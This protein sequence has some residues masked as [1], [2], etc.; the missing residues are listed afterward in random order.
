MKFWVVGITLFCWGNLAFG[1]CEPED[2][3]PDHYVIRFS[4][5]V[6]SSAFQNL[7][8][9]TRFFR[10]LDLAKTRSS[11][12]KIPETVVAKIN[13]SE[14]SRFISDYGSSVKSIEPVCRY[15]LFGTINPID[16]DFSKQWNL[17][18]IKAPTAWARTTGLN[19]IV[20]AISDSGVDWKHHEFDGRIW[21]N[22]KEVPGNGIDDDRNGCI[23]DIHGCDTAEQDGDPSPPAG[24]EEHGHGTHVAGIVAAGMNAAGIVGVAPLVT[25]MPVKGFEDNLSGIT[26]GIG[27]VESIY[28]AVN[29][30]ARVINCSWGRRGLATQYEKDAINYALSQGVVVVAAAGNSSADAQ[31]FT[32]ANIPGVLV[33]GATGKNDQLASFSNYGSRLDVVAPGGAGYSAGNMIDPILS[34]FPLE[35]GGY[36]ELI[37]TSMAAPHVAGAAALILS[38]ND[39]F[40]PQDIT[41]ILKE[42]ASLISVTGANGI[43]YQVRRLDLASALDLAQTTLPTSSPSPCQGASCPQSQ[44]SQTLSSSAPSSQ[45][46]GG[47]GTLTTGRRSFND[48]GKKIWAWLLAMPIL[49]ALLLRFRLRLFQQVGKR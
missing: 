33:V 44:G 10:G 12:F 7:R 23:D 47:C 43:N 37:G 2:V 41:K 21:T 14:K 1:Q 4:S 30:G 46:G 31:F 25:I 36:R 39:K 16:R 15:K 13:D 9:R 8:N 34:T 27:L 11:G 49:F 48:Q 24:S 5:A 26:S 28:Y 3:V 32:P 20:V 42:S 35:F 40:S 6:S 18:K 19:K 45:T 22:S 29:N 17:E 38:I